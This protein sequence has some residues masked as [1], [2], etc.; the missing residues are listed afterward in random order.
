MYPFKIPNYKENNIVNLMSSISHSFWSTHSYNTLECLPP[1]ELNKFKN[2]VLLV[3]DALGYNYLNKQKDSFLYK[4]L[5][6]KLGSTFFSGTASANT[7]F[8]VGY[9]PQQHGFTGWTMNIKEVGGRVKPLIFTKGLSKKS[10]L[11]DGFKIED[12]LKIESFHKDFKRECFTI[13]EREKSKRDFIKYV[14]KNTTLIW[15]EDYKNVFAQISE[16]ITKDSTKRKFIHGYMDEFDTVQHKYGIIS[17]ETKT[18]FSSIDTRVQKLSESL[19]GTDTQLIVVSDHGMIPLSERSEIFVED[20]SGLLECL[21]MPIVGDPRVRDCFIYPDKIEEFKR[22]IETEMSQY[23][24][25]FDGAQLIEDNFYGLGEVNKKLYE[26]VGDFVLIMKE[27]Y[28]LYS[29][30]KDNQRAAAHGSTTDEEI[31]VPLILINC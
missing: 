14:A 3:V 13:I 25:C 1:S 15:V 30:T 7:V 28:V 18:L 9:P 22:I 20:F 27:D 11:E 31:D 2:V 24:W 12:I 8:H 16:L 21:T 10:L 29:H 4:H 23:C 19:Q 5:H 26:R 6:S 17:K